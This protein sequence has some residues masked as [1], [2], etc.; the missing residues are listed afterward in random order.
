MVRGAYRGAH[1]LPNADIGK[2]HSQIIQNRLGIGEVRVVGLPRDVE[3][4]HLSTRPRIAQMGALAQ[5]H[6][7]TWP[8]S[9]TSLDF[10]MMRSQY[11]VVASM[12]IAMVDAINKC[13]GEGGRCRSALPPPVEA[14]L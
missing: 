8:E 14:S 2:V 7:N 4:R 5:S 12:V 1:V 3:L 13:P 9:L 11:L 10:M 6:N